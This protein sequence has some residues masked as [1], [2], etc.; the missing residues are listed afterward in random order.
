MSQPLPY[1]YS[2]FSGTLV[3]YQEPNATLMAN[4]TE[5]H[6]HFKPYSSLFSSYPLLPLEVSP[7]GAST[8]PNTSTTRPPPVPDLRPLKY[9]TFLRTLSSQQLQNATLCQYEVPGGGE[10]RDDQCE[11]LHLS[12]MPTEPSGA[13]PPCLSHAPSS[14]V[15]LSHS[16]PRVPFV[17]MLLL[18]P[19][20]F[21]LSTDEEI[22]SYL[23][24]ALPEDLQSRVGPT[25]LLEEV[26][27][28]R[29][30]QA[31]AGLDARIGAVWTTLFG[32]VAVSA[33]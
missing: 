10:C 20:L 18:S 14:F 33:Q 2:R 21:P 28:A 16:P 27:Q 5:A 32:P 25:Q 1:S 23:H 11:D 3:S 9:Q 8:S 29:T 7:G 19:L 12:R 24:G 30:R 4:S 31:P 26:R 22:A 15:V 6:P 17:S 13:P